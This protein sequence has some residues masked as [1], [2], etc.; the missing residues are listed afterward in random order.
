MLH[1]P[2]IERLLLLVVFCPENIITLGFSVHVVWVIAYNNAPANW[3]NWCRPGRR[4]V[5]I[6]TRSTAW[7][8]SRI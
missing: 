1:A 4:A 3:M 7:T 8:W 2:I 6:R 5:C